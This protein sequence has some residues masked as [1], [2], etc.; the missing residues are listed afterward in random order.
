[1]SLT[2]ASPGVVR[3]LAFSRLQGMTPYQIN[4]LLWYYVRPVDY[5]EPSPILQETID[6]FI[7]K[8]LL[9]PVPVGYLYDAKYRGTDRLKCYAKAL[10]DVPLPTWTV[11][12]P[13]TCPVTD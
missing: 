5:A 6:D 9:E 12:W 10:Q 2:A 8:G 7:A 3:P 1:M 13:K 11:V 4:I